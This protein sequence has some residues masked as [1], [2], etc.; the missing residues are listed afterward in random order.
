M[1]RRGRPVLAAICGFFLG[2]F[3]ALDLMFFGAVRLDNI[4]ITVLPI[5]GLLAGAGLAI[6]A[7]LGRRQ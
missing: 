4:A 5:V 1:N 6:W 2:L 7:P 3:I